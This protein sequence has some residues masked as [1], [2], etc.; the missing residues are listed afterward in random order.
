MVGDQRSAGG[1]R[2]MLVSVDELMARIDRDDPRK[3]RQSAYLVGLARIRRLEGGSERLHTA[4]PI[5]PTGPAEPASC[6]G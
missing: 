4:Q 6:E 5:A 3:L 2:K 1:M